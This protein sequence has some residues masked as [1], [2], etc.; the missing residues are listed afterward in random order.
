MIRSARAVVIVVLLCAAT[1]TLWFPAAA[2]QGVDASAKQLY[3]N[4][5]AFLEQGNYVAAMKDFDTVVTSY[6]SSPAAVSALLQIM[7][8]QLDVV[9]DP[10]AAH[11]TAETLIKKYPLSD[12]RS[13]AYI[14][15]G[16]STLATGR[17]PADLDAALSAFDRVPR[18]FA[19][20]DDVPISLY[21]AGE[22]LRIGGRFDEAIAKYRDVSLQYPRTIWAAR[23]ALGAAIC[24][25]FKGTPLEA[26]DELERVRQ[27]FPGTAEANRALAWNTALYRLF[28]TGSNQAAYTFSGRAVGGPSG[29]LKDVLALAVTSGDDLLVVGR[30]SVM[31]FKPDGSFLRQVSNLPAQD[32][33]TDPSGALVVLSKGG[34]QPERGTPV[35]LSIPKPDNTPKRMEALT[36]A[37]SDSTGDVLIGDGDSKTILRFSNTG[38]PLGRFA[39]E[40]PDRLAINALDE[41]A[42]L[43]RDAK[44]IAIIDRTGKTL[45]RIPTKGTGYVMRNPIDLAYD[46]LGHLFVLD[47]G[48]GA[49]FIFDHAAKLVSM[50][51]I[52]EKSPGAFRG[53]TAITLD[54]AARLLIYDTQTERVQIYQ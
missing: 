54:S 7:K 24:L 37:V 23:A 45:H 27:R 28:L 48:A 13:M 8:Y 50:F 21:Y 9:R 33:F 25:S 1:G 30:Q 38:K 31:A 22:T 18:M 51:S 2:G 47:R 6:P 20:S 35:L 34:F 44:T 53:A 36:S 14:V 15:S 12:G 29:K 40:R 4:G 46:A 17:T 11:A 5:V 3:E 41:V 26:F 32:L 52:A 49:V 19:R 10:V 16:R 42:A 39:A 43:D